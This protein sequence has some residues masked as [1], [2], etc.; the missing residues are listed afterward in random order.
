MRTHWGQG[1][2]TEIAGAL[3]NLWLTKLHSLSLVGVVSV[4]NAASSRVL[5]KSGFVFER[6]GIYHGTEVGIFRRTRP[7]HS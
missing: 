1:L 6:A 5:E 7:A 3:I 2:A 4:E